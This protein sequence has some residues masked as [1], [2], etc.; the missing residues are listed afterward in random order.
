MKND[1]LSKIIAR[2]E[3]KAKATIYGEGHINDTYLAQVDPNKYILQ[4]INHDIFKDVEKL[5]QNIAAVTSHLHE[6]ILLR[7]GDPMRETLSVIKTADGAYFT[8]TESGNYYR[9]YVYVD[10]TNTYQSVQSPTLF[11]N[12]AKAFGKFQNDLSDFQADVLTETIPNFHNTRSRFEDLRRAVSEDKAGRKAE[13][14]QEIAFAMAREAEAG[15]VCNALESGEIPLRVTHNDTKLNN[16]L[17]DK[18]TGEGICVIDLDTVMPGS[19]LYDFGDSVRFGASTAAE[20]EKDLSKVECSMELFEAFTKG[21]LEEL[22]ESITKKEL[23][24]LAFSAKLMTYECG[25]RFLTDYLNGDIY[26]KTHRP[27]QNLDRCRTQFKL[28]E[29][30]EKKMARMNAIVGELSAE[31]RK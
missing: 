29:D 10:D 31:C 19:L 25:M 9:L 16:V 30:M 8:E 15:I 17:F 13:V 11:Y 22:G 20:D 3:L 12:A 18:E 1:D 4:R 23:E 26:F 5:M 7:G 28:I 2:F 6:K 24:L 14:A 27:K 21:F